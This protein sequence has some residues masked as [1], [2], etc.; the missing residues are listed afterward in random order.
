MSYLS[1]RDIE[2]HNECKK[3]SLCFGC[4]VNPYECFHFRRPPCSI[5]FRLCPECGRAYT[6]APAISRRSGGN[7]ICPECGMREAL[8]DWKQEND[9]C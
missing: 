9:N 4:P 6:D 2:I 3:H 1:D 8:E 7:E 5:V